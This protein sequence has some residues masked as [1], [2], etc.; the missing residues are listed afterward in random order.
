MVVTEGEGGGGGMKKV[1]GVRYMATEETRLCVVKDHEHIQM[2][3][4][5]VKPLKFI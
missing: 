3:Y 2:S 5:Q 4:Y 1:K